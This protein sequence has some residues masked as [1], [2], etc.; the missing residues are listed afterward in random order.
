[1]KRCLWIL[2]ASI[3]L[4][5]C[6]SVKNTQALQRGRSNFESGYYREAFQQLL[7]LASEGDREAEYAI[8]Y[9]YYYGYGVSQD[10]ETGIFW[11]QKSADQKFDPAVRA[12]KDLR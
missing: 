11:I 5:S 3:L 9:M 1:M 12:L 10:S 8:G 6:A 7:P 2:V 4:M